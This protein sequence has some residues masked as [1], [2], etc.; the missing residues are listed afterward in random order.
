MGTVGQHTNTC[1]YPLNIRVLLVMNKTSNNYPDHLYLLPLSSGT[2]HWCPPRRT[3]LVLKKKK[4]RRITA[5]YSTTTAL[6]PVTMREGWLQNWPEIA[7]VLW[8]RARKW[9]EVAVLLVPVRKRLEI[10]WLLCGLQHGIRASVPFVNQTA[11]TQQPPGHNNRLDT[12]TAWTRKYETCFGKKWETRCDS[13]FYLFPTLCCV[14]LLLVT[15][16][17]GRYLSPLFLFCI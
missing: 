16:L 5:D 9:R 1:A 12:T 6:L 11:W 15:Y 2:N 8:F 13:V 10:A 7:C 4:K 14:L 17:P 3:N